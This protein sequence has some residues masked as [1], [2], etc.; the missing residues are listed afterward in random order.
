MIFY[1][2]RMEYPGFESAH[3]CRRYA[4]RAM[5]GISGRE[6]IPREAINQQLHSAH[7]IH[8]FKLGL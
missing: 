5:S 7:I 4:G 6:K 2:A 8:T 1:G 3:S